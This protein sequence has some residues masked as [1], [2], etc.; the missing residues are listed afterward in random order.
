MSQKR[1]TGVWSTGLGFTQHFAWIRDLVFGSRSRDELVKEL[2]R[3]CDVR[4]GDPSR[5]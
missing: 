2:R 4:A 1:K 5:V 3:N